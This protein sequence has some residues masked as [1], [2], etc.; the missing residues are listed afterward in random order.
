[1][2]FFF[3]IKDKALV[4]LKIFLLKK[5]KEVNDEYKEVKIKFPTCILKDNMNFKKAIIDI[6][7][8]KAKIVEEMIL[9][10]CNL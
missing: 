10:I 4:I 8:E 1:M 2:I 5:K 7:S 6:S 9:S 3:R